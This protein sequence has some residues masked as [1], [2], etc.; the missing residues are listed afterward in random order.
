MSIPLG[1]KPDYPRKPLP[2][3]PDPSLL[4][5][6]EAMCAILPNHINISER[7]FVTLFGRGIQVQAQA[8]QPGSNDTIHILKCLHQFGVGIE[9]DFTILYEQG[10]DKRITT[11]PV[12]FVEPTVELLD[13]PSE[14]LPL[15]R[16]RLRYVDLL[17]HGQIVPD[18]L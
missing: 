7:A 1:N 17:L 4:E 13:A 11:I 14:S 5:H 12:R 2:I 6:V 18:D 3:I 8:S 9:F 16:L 15:G 10:I